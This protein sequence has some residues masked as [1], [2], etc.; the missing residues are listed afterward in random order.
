MRLPPILRVLLIQLIAALG[1]GLIFRQAAYPFSVWEIAFLTG[2]FAGLIT[3]LLRLPRW[4]LPVQVLF[5]PLVVAALML[6]LP[7][8]LYLAGF[9]ALSLVYWSTYRTQIPLYLSS[10]QACIALEQIISD[11]GKK[12]FIDIGAGVGST[13]S[14]LSAARPEGVYVGVENAPVPFIFAWL[15]LRHLKNCSMRRADFWKID[16]GE[17]DIVYAYLSPVPMTELWK[18]ARKEMRQGSFLISNTF[19]VPGQ[20]PDRILQLDDFHHSRLLLWKM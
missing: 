2:F 6:E 8:W 9:I 12:H 11:S 1:A 13:L 14:H 16:L 18:K 15:R 19:E 20:P 7:A 17:F 10:H 3:F 4:W 5:A